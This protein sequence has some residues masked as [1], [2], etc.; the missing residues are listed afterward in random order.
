MITYYDEDGDEI[1]DLPTC[2][3]I[4][5]MCHGNGATS[6]HLGVI[7]HDEWDDD[8]FRAYVNGAYDKTC[9]ECKGAGKV[10]VLDYDRLTPEQAEDCNNQD[11]Q[12][13]EN[14]AEMESER[15]MGC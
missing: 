12:E 4:C 15:R 10:K 9:E 6:A 2:W 13:S 5:A 1:E 3:E 14:R 11:N 7:N 8:E